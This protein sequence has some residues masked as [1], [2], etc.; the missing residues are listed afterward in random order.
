MAKLTQKQI[1]A[2]ARAE[3]L[4]TSDKTLT[5]DDIG[6]ILTDW[7]EGATHSNASTS[8]F[9]TPFELAM[10]FALEVPEGG[11]ILD[12]CSGI[13]MLSA[14]AAIYHARNPGELQFTMVELDP[15]YADVARRLL[16]EADVICGSIFDPAIQ[17]QLAEQHFDV[18]ISNPPYGNRNIAAGNG[19]R[20]TGA[21]CEYAI[22][23]IA[24][25]LADTGVFLIPQA[26][27]PFR[28]SGTHFMHAAK[29]SELREYRKFVS[30]TGIELLPNMGIDTS[31]AEPMWRGTSIR[32]EIALCDF[33][34]IRSKRLA[35]P[36]DGQQSTDQQLSLSLAA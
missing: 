13:G 32:T 23:D 8:A 14:A 6:D 12:I 2:H 15:V 33:A 28:I 24:S 9:F 31:F 22:I 26:S 21:K 25:D 27:V 7:H 18:A 5:L 30:Q 35:S 11:R 34:E 20:Y 16:P 36:N 3:A 1:K 29:E 4:L 17:E 19:P 10:N